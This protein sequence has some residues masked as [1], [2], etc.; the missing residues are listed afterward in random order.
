MDGRRKSRSWDAQ[1]V[2]RSARF[3]KHGRPVDAEDYFFPQNE[4]N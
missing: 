3:A 1:T 2:V 4:T